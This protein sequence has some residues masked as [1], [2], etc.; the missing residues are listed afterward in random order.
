LGR[1]FALFIALIVVLAAGPLKAQE[2]EFGEGN[3]LY[4]DKDYPGAIESYQEVLS[5]GVES[6]A[7]YYNL[8]N[9]YFKAG[10]LGY[11]VLNYLRARRLA[12]SDENVR[13]NLEFAKR[14]SRVQMEGVT[15]NPIHS[16]LTDIVG[17]YRFDTLAWL[18]SCCFVLFMVV[19]IVRF[20]VGFSTTVVRALT[21]ALLILLLVSVG[22]AG[23]KY[24]MDYLTRLAVIVADESP[25][26]TGPSRSSEIELRGAPGLVVEIVAESGDFYNVLF[27]N[28]RRG[29]IKKELLSEV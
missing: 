4:A 5:G 7:L 22:L 27:E 23:F 15:L 26:Y 1:R 16:L 18:A 19:L 12:P 20:G 13:H 9:A 14:L 21:W 2:A 29:W 28:K 25:V 3:R 17:N 24:R 11:A 6:A 8:G 10:D